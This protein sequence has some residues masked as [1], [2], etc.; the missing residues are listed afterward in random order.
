MRQGFAILSLAAALVCGTCLLTSSTASAGSA[1]PTAAATCSLERLSVTVASG[2]AA[3]GSEGMLAFR[4]KGTS[5]C[6]LQ[7]YPKVVATRRGSSS[8]AKASA[9]SYLGD[10][11][12]NHSLRLSA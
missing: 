1:S 9:N 3:G 12:P 11:H 6:N 5:T 4:N 2:G 8:T 7:G 10:W